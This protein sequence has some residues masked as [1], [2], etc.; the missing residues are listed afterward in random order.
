V[1]GV[2][3]FGSVEVVGPAAKVEVSCERRATQGEGVHV[4][5]L[6]LVAGGARVAGTADERA[7]SAIAP[8]HL[9]AHGCGT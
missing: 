2:D 3:L 1:V 5:K 8:P 4:M 7:L 6:E 9:V